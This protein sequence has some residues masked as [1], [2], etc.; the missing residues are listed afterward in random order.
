MILDDIQIIDPIDP[1]S[2]RRSLDGLC[3]YKLHDPLSNYEN[4]VAINYIRQSYPS[5]EIKTWD[6]C[7]REDSCFQLNYSFIRNIDSLRLISLQ[8]ILSELT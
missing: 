2:R 1:S 3:Q 7:T 8:T 6:V 5:L 4:T